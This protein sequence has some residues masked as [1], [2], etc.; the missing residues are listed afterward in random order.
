MNI[1]IYV[2]C[3]NDET[4]D[5]ACRDYAGKD[6]AKPIIIKTTALL[7]NIMYDEWLQANEN[8]WKDCDYVGTLSWKASQK[9]NIADIFE[10]IY[11]INNFEEMQTFDIVPF[12]LTEYNLVEQATEHHPKFKGLWFRLMQELGITENKALDADI[13]PFFCNYWMCKSKL[14]YSYIE[15]FKKAKNV[16]EICPELQDDLWSDALY[17]ANTLSVDKCMQ[18]YNKKYIPYHVFLYERIPSIF[19]HLQKAH[20]FRRP[21][22]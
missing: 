9:I 1:R 16:L 7:E 3:Y 4:Y 14:M 17:K 10:L 6:W 5:I 8:D 2:L 19:F 20:M 11:I 18:L 22:I 15:F 12:Y 13:M 21:L